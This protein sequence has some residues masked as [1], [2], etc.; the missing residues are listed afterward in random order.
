MA[1][2]DAIRQQ[3]RTTTMTTPPP[4]PAAS[5]RPRNRFGSSPRRPGV[6]AGVGPIVLVAAHLGPPLDRRPPS[7]PN[8]VTDNRARPSDRPPMGA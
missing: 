5:H 6:A 7:G 4:G 8:R 1:A 3:L 2:G